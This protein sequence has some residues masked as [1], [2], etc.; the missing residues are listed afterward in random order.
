MSSSVVFVVQRVAYEE[1][2]WHGE[3]KRFHEHHVGEQPAGRPEAAFVTRGAA[4]EYRRGKEREV[5]S[6]GNPFDW[7]SDFEAASNF[8]EPVFRDFVYDLTGLS[9]PEPDAEGHSD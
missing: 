5:W 3:G 4:E 2:P 1:D 9:G 8:A 6:W 7:E